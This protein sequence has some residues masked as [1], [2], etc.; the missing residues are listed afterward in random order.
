MEKEESSRCRKCRSVKS[1][2]KNELKQQL[3]RRILKRLNLTNGRSCWRNYQDKD[4]VELWADGVVVVVKEKLHGD[5]LYLLRK[6]CCH[7]AVVQVLQP[8]NFGHLRMLTL[9]GKRFLVNL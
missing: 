8:H 6:E 5:A 4:L 2:D 3:E 7:S 9:R 1:L